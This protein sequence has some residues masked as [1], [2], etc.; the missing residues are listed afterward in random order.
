[1]KYSIIENNGRYRIVNKQGEW[2][3]KIGDSEG[4]SYG[5]E[6]IWETRFKS[7]ALK[8]LASIDPSQ[9]KEVK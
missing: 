6:G 8:R 1:M 3:W 4:F 2:F 9:W 7:R 5:S